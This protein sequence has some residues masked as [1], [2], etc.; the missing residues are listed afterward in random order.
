MICVIMLSLA[1]TIVVILGNYTICGML[2]F[3]MVSVAFL[4]FAMLRVTTLCL[5][6]TIVV[7]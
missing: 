2:S 5:V 3:V 1:R 7:M 4:N 6:I